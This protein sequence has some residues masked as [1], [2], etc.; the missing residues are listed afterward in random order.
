[1]Q[2][3]LFRRHLAQATLLQNCGPNT[4][5]NQASGHLTCN[6]RVIYDGVKEDEEHSFAG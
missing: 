5:S 4:D 2:Q 1:M 3:F 6:D